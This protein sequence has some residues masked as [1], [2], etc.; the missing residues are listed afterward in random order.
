MLVFTLLGGG[1]ASAQPVFDAGIGTWISQGSTR[2]SHDASSVCSVCGN[3][4]SELHYKDL[5]SNVIEAQGRVTLAKRLFLR[6][7]Y[8]FGEIHGGRLIDDDYVSAAGAAFYGATVGGPHR[9]SRT[10]SDVNGSHLWYVNADIG[11]RLLSFFNERGSLRLFLGYQYWKEKVEATGVTQ[12]ECTSPGNFCNPAGTV[13]NRGEKASTNTVQWHSLRLGL[14]GGYQ[15]VPRLSIDGRVV[16]IPRASMQNK[17]IHHLRSDLQKNPSFSMSGTGMG[18]NAD[19]SASVMII[20]QLFVTVGYRYWWLEVTD[21]TWRNHPVSGASSTVNLNEL[22][23]I[24]QG[25][26][27]GL[28][29]TF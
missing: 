17:D 16:F 2:W 20:N 14:E 13:S 12:V 22:R 25:V 27:L 19:V 21:G 8:G 11:H 29:Y 4:T 5:W 10:F 18:V 28:T 1:Q 3:P 26:T 24:R 6:A 15:V 9:I 7:T 23:S